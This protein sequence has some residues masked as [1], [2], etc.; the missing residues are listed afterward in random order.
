M[1]K[2]K[3]IAAILIPK[4]DSVRTASQAKRIAIQ[5]GYLDTYGCTEGPGFFRL[6][7]SDQDMH[8][9]KTAKRRVNGIKTVRGE[10]L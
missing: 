3:E 8:G 10:F 6:P 2:P 5:K 7:Q 4:S 1:S 9:F